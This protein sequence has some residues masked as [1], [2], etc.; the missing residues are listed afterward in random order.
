M[1]EFELQR[2]LRGLREPI[3][4]Q[5]DLWSG[6]E[7]RIDPTHRLPAMPARRRW[8]MALAASLFVGVLSS[9]ALMSMQTQAPNEPAVSVSNSESVKVRIERA[10]QQARSGDPRLAGSEVVLDSAISELEAALQQQPDATFL[11]GLI[12]R[13]HAQQRRIARLGLDAG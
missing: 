3:A 9:V 8:P 4:P 7:S 12:N 10:R 13:T 5:R 11:V 6:I 1:S 2:Q